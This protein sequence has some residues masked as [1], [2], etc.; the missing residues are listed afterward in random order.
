MRVTHLYPR[1]FCVA[2]M[3]LSLQSSHATLYTND[4]FNYPAGNLSTAAP[5]S[6]AGSN[7]KMIAGDLTYIGLSAPSP[8]PA[9]ST[10][11]QCLGSSADGKR[12][13]NSTAVGGPAT[14]ESIY[15]SFLLR[16]T[17]LAASSGPLLALSD[18]TSVGSGGNS[19][20]GRR[21]TCGAR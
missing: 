10:K 5:W 8:T 18:V 4:F 12:T 7:L 3:L 15:V 6:G 9:N 1:I 16:Q 17:T 13:F 20:T 21:G 19:N 14:T 11:A 2:L